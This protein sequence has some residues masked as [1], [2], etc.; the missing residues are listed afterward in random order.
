[1]CFNRICLFLPSK[2]WTLRNLL[3]F[4]R[5]RYLVL[6]RIRFRNGPKILNLFPAR[7]RS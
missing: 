3:L 4:Y 6:G 1:M 5:K 2:M 7:F